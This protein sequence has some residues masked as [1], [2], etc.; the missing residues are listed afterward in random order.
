MRLHHS[1]E[2][3]GGQRVLRFYRYPVK[4]RKLKLKL[5]IL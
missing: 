3:N 5:D 2:R 1:A 4:K